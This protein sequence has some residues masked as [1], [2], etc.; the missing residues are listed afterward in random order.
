MKQY[1]S[2]R[3]QKDK[4]YKWKKTKKCLKDTTATEKRSINYSRKGKEVL[5]LGQLI[6]IAYAKVIFDN[7]TLV[8]NFL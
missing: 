3:K 6:V 4:V 5:V 1:E 7:R 8:N 2:V